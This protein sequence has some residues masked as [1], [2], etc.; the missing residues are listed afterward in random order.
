MSRPCSL[1]KRHRDWSWFGNQGSGRQAIAGGVVWAEEFKV[2]RRCTKNSGH[3][4]RELCKAFRVPAAQRAAEHFGHRHKPAKHLGYRRSAC[5]ASR[6]PARPAEH[7]GH[8]YRACRASRVRRA[9]QKHA[10]HFGHRHGAEHFGYR[11]KHA[12]R[13][14][15]TGIS[16]Q[17]ISGTG[18]GG[19]R[20]RASRAPAS[21]RRAS[22][23]PA[24]ARRA[25]F[26]YRRRARRASRAP[27]SAR[28]ASWA[29]A[30]APQSISGTGGRPQSISGTGISTQSISV[31]GVGGSAEHGYRRKLPQIN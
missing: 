14:W 27:A 30:S 5:R 12:R 6:V 16:T 3:P 13:L 10:E 28:R 23:A 20:R 1:R 18:M 31:Y 21:A 4:A 11:Q 24:S 8:R 25:Y 2:G 17:S 22:R 26:G 15:G 7:L 29:P 9:W 19:G